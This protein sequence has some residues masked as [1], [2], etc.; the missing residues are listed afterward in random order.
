MP[1]PQFVGTDAVQRDNQALLT[2]G[3]A[4]TVSFGGGGFAA[5][6]NVPAHGGGGYWQVELSTA[7]RA[8][9][10]VDVQVSHANGSYPATKTYINVEALVG[11]VQVG[12]LDAD[13]ITAA[14]IAA[15]ALNG[16]GN[17]NVNKSGYSLVADQSSVTFGQVNA[18]GT[19]AITAGA[20]VASALND[21]G[22]WNVDK[23]GYGLAT[24]AITAAVIQDA[25]I[26]AA[27]FAANAISAAAFSQLAA[28]KAKADTSALALE[29]TVLAVGAVVNN[30]DTKVDAT[31]SSRSSHNAAAV[32]TE[33]EDIIIEALPAGN[34][35]LKNSLRLSNAMAAGLLSGAK[36]ATLTIR[37]LQDTVDRVVATVDGDGNRQAITLDLT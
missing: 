7:E 13:V 20:I 35:S 23:T 11:N 31:V 29:G 37:N 24:N 17:W 1:L 34:I 14:S 25:A 5:P 36:T 28:D 32:A 10:Q 2:A 4:L 26:T 3:V 30:I 27:K 19:G 33:V 21:K 6:A 18:L 22:N 12:G 8:N 9:A 16:K 15:G